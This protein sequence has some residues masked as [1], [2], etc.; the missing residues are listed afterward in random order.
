MRKIYKLDVV[1][2]DLQPAPIPAEDIVSGDPKARW[3]VMWQSDDGRLFN[4]VWHC[5]PGAFY[6]DNA[7]ET[8][9]LIEGRATVTPEGGDPVDL[10]AGDTAFLPE[11]SRS[12]W[13][14]HETVRKSFHHHDSSGQMLAG[15]A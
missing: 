4:G 15:G 6:L 5:T 9:C 1:S 12:L 14:I 13:D 7:D 11:G 8:V 2:A 3:A 10:K